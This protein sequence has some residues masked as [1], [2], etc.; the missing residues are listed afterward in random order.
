MATKDLRQ[1]YTITVAPTPNLVLLLV[2][3]I[4]LAWIND[5]S[6]AVPVLLRIQGKPTSGQMGCILITVGTKTL[7]RTSSVSLDP[8]CPLG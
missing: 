6:L 3:F 5:F 7:S 1:S 4:F 8:E 2:I